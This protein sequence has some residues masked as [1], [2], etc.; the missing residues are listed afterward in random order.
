[1]PVL[2]IARNLISSDASLEFPPMNDADHAAAAEP[3][4]FHSLIEALRR[5]D[6]RAAAEIHRRLSERLTKLA[7]R[8]IPDPIRA[9]VDAE[10]IVQSAFRGFFTH[11]VKGEYQLQSWQDLEKLLTRMTMRRCNRERLRYI[12]QSRNYHIEA[13]LDDPD[14]SDDSHL[15]DNADSPQDR[16]ILAET[17]QRLLD[18]LAPRDRE[19]VRLAIEGK[20]ANEIAEH[21][22]VSRRTADR[23]VENFRRQIKDTTGY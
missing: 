10:D 13:R 2:M 15:I 16:V 22:G 18:D 19:I 17:F 12:T 8:R 23:I 11:Q 3:S 4:D 21:V 1:M 6:K 20:K 14:A 7:R 5:G 9:K